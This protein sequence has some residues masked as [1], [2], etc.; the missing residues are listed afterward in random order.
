[1]NVGTGIVQLQEALKL[2]RL[3]W[4]TTEQFWNDQVKRQFETDFLI[5]L[6]MQVKATHQAMEQLAQLITQAKHDVSL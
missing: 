1:M 5:P 6:E 3:Q 2:L 4:E